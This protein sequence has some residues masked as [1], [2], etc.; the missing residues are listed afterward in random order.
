MAQILDHSY[1]ILV[2]KG[3]GYGE[4][5]SLFN[6]ISHQPVIDKIY[7]YAKNPYETNY[8]LLI[9]KRKNAGLNHLN[10]PKSF[11]EYSDDMDGSYLKKY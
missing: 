7:L 6:W 5:N 3:S 4:T 11:I 2:F 10:N 1:R 8:Q 9:N